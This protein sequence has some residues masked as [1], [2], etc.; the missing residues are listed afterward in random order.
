MSALR[1]ASTCCGCRC[2]LPSSCAPAAPPNL[3]ARRR[4]RRE[5]M[6]LVR[7]QGS[8]CL[9]GRGW[10]GRRPRADGCWL[11]SRPPKRRYQRGG[12]GITWGGKRKPA[13]ADRETGAGRG[14]ILMPAV[15]LLCLRRTQQCHGSSVSMHQRVPMASKAKVDPTAGAG[16]AGTRRAVSMSAMDAKE[17]GRSGSADVTDPAAHL[18]VAVVEE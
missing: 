2:W 13:K 8:A 12:R 5:T 9:E 7:K 14:R 17:T 11:R 6:K 16:G 18:R 15:L 1:S 10:T 3:A 4:E